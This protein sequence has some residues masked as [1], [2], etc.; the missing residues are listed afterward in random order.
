MGVWHLQMDLDS[1]PGT[2]WVDLVDHG[3][4]CDGYGVERGCLGVTADDP[5]VMI[6]LHN[7]RTIYSYTA[8]SVQLLIRHHPTIHRDN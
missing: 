8:T 3:A 2:D 6:T 1:G 5:N 7:I 4:K